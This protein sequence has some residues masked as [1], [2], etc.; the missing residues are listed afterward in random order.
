VTRCRSK[1][2]SARLGHIVESKPAA[3]RSMDRPHQPAGN[4]GVQW[5]WHAVPG[6]RAGGVDGVCALRQGA[7]RPST[8]LAPTLP[9]SAF[10]FRAGIAI[11]TLSAPRTA[12]ARNRYFDVWM[13]GVRRTLWC[14]R[15]DH[16]LLHFAGVRAYMARRR[17]PV[18]SENTPQTPDAQSWR[19]RPE[20][21][22]HHQPGECGRVLQR[23][24]DHTSYR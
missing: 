22:Q 24:S 7:R 12:V 21:V 18:R 6:R 17:W 15:D 4:Q 14:G 20:Q 8:L 2:G 16:G 13:Q 11:S 3:I 19:C 5:I 9:G 10:D 1:M 23:N